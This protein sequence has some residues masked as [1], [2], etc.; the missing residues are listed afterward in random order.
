LKIY[1]YNL[2]SF[3][4]FVIIIGDNTINFWTFPIYKEGIL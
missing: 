2:I 4:I 3:I 1:G